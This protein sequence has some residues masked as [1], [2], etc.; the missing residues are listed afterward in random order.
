MKTSFTILFLLLTMW[1]YSQFNRQQRVEFLDITA[2][3]RVN[4]FG[5]IGA[6]SP[7]FYKD[8]GLYQNP[9]LL[10]KSPDLTSGI[11]SSIMP[12]MK[13]SDIYL[14]HWDGFVSIDEK[15]SIGFNRREL[16]Y[17]DVMFTDNFG[18]SMGVINPKEVSYQ[19]TYSRSLNKN[20]ALGIGLKYFKS[21]LTRGMSVGV[22]ETKPA[23]SYALDF[24]AIYEKAKS[25]LDNSNLNY[26]FAG[27]IS[28]FG[29]R[30]SYT[31]AYGA[32]DHIATKLRLG[33]MINPDF[34]LSDE[35]RLNASIA[36]QA[37]KFL[38]PTPPTLA[39]DEYGNPI[40]DDNGNV[41]ISSGKDPDISAFRALYQSFYDAPDGMKEEMQEVIHKIGGEL[42]FS[43]QNK[44]YLALRSGY[45]Y[46]HENKGNRKIFSKGF[47]I[48]VF[49][50]TI[51]Y[52]HF[53]SEET[54]PWALTFG[55]RS[56][57]TNF[58]S[59]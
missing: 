21:D 58:P 22:I 14:F 17:G 31:P 10:F 8:A 38:V 29:P 34:Y 39:L 41:V 48:G 7:N 50:F 44:G 6:V 53:K 28:N 12:L 26:A 42:R 3:A 13:N 19:L 2:N 20:F 5:Q 40:Y 56:N 37:E 49:G 18:Y 59:F 27:G 15:N 45:V 43:Y 57:F 51:D 36:Y 24:G 30:I 54:W 16:D 4:A 25:I 47:G 33:A 32:K 9:A 52:Y 55:F 23:K 1:A 35:F 46:E 11:S